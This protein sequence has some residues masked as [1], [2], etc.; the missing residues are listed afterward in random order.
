MRATRGIAFRLA[1]AILVPAGLIFAAAFGYNYFVSRRILLANI[2]ENARNVT[3]VTVGRIDSVLR[4]VEKVPQNIAYAL[5]DAAYSRNAVAS[6]LR[7]VVENNPEI[8]GATIAFEPGERYGD[9][10]A[11]YF[12]KSDDRILSSDLA[13][14]SYRYFGW[15]WYRVPKEL[16]RA[17]WSEPYDDRGGGNVIMSTYSVPFHAREGDARRF[18]G[19]VTADVYLSWLQEIVASIRIARTGYGFL[20]SRNGT[21]V[22]HPRR[23]QIMNE[24]IFSVAAASGDPRLRA[25][26]DEMV[27]GGA[28]FAPSRSIVTGRECWIAYAPV[29]S[30]GWS[31]GVIFPRDEL[32][33]DVSRL[34]RTVASIGAAGIAFLFAVVVLIARTITK[35]LRTLSRATRNIGRGDLDF[36]LPAIG[37]RDEVGRLAGSF[38]YMRDS[39]RRHIAELTAAT[40]ARER[41]ESELA[42][43][44]RIQMG[45]V[46]KTFPA[47]PARREFDLHAVLEP[48]REVGGDLYDFFLVGDDRL[49]LTIGDVSGKGVPAALFMALVKT[50][51]KAAARGGASPAAALEAVNG[52]MAADNDECMF[53]SVWCGALETAT[54]E[55][56]WSSAGHNPPVLAR[57]GGEVS[58]LAEGGGPVLGVVPGARYAAASFRLRRGDTLCLYTDGVTEA[59]NGRGEQF[60][61]ERLARAVAARRVGSAREVVRG[62][63]EDVR[64]FAGRAPQSDDITVVALRYEGAG[65][66]A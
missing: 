57:A 43:A 66:D 60:S 16:G 5:E 47:F 24:T 26:A 20:V 44:H 59:F 8:Y 28:G 36:E 17:V 33:A 19:I 39:L 11:P 48:A 56:R 65:G 52:E 64:S 54:G 29:P 55:L 45:I 13:D 32:L 61:E 40:A 42:I 6:L 58:F 50:L 23:G 34:N 12:Y 51:V 3:A 30:A 31:L 4:A 22:T 1:V 15:D 14:D 63:L 7:T 10:F 21:F 41:M 38:A 9:G 25:I 18:A 35:P 37:P 2:E 46:P 62:I 53:V 27:R 49:W